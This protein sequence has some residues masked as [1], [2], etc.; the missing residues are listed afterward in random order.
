M[1]LLSVPLNT[2]R[3]RS[4]R[5]YP[6]W[7]GQI[8]TASSGLP[9]M[10]IWARYPHGLGI[11]LDHEK[12]SVFRG[13]IK[14]EYDSFVMGRTDSKQPYVPVVAGI[15]STLHPAGAAEATIADDKVMALTS[16]DLPEAVQR[17]IDIYFGRAAPFPAASNR[18]GRP[19]ID[20]RSR[21]VLDFDAFVA[22]FDTITSI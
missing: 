10:A 2:V 20:C 18:G 19:F 12:G 21:A 7:L 6:A 11:Y 9:T 15:L 22:K 16:D 5:T 14:K 13:V 4:T 1:G 17:L 3:S 8:Q